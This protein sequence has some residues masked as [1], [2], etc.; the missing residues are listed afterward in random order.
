MIPTARSYNDK[1]LDTLAHPNK[2]ARPRGCQCD[3]RI[4]T[5]AL[6]FDLHTER[7][8]ARPNSQGYAADT[9]M[10][11]DV[12]QRFFRDAVS[13][14][15]HLGR[16]AFC[17]SLM[18]EGYQNPGLVRVTLAKCQQGGQQP[19]LIQGRGSQVERQP[20]HGLE[21]F[22]DEAASLVQAG[23]DRVGR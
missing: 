18:L 5:A 9:S 12:G 21:E 13:S 6:I 15:L 20:A 8:R 4:E 10:A 11:G 22:I 16:K 3:L 14:C 17:H 19:E 23:F 7:V 2:A 1:Q